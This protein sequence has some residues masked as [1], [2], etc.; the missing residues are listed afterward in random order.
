MVATV[1]VGGG[2]WSWE[3]WIKPRYIV[4]NFG[5]VEAGQV[6][7]SGRLTP[8]TLTKVAKE[9]KIR[10][11]IDFGADARGSAADV[12]EQRT[13]EALGVSR[14]RLELS[15]DATG[16]PNMYVE[17][18]RVMADPANHP[19]LVHCGAGAQRTGAVVVLYRHLVQGKKIS[20]VYPEAFEF[21]HDPGKDYA[22]PTYLAD[23][24]DEIEE[25]FRT[26]EPIPVRMVN[27]KAYKAEP[28]GR[29]SASE[30]KPGAG[31]GNG[32]GAGSATGS[33]SGPGAG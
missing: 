30:A 13:C 32:A 16:D 14:L 26:G 12:A 23:W 5:V 10:T 20:D 24:A 2:L 25:S 8:A 7:R 28:S 31:A 1:V 9:R 29:G 21:G 17:A 11:V 19:V 4:K 27:G 6:Y 15:G 3:S 18:L 22:L 33:G